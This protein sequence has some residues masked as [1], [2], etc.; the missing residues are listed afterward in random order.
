MCGGT[1]R[2]LTALL[3]T[4]AMGY[5]SRRSATDLDATPR[6]T[7]TFDELSGVRRF[8]GH[9][10]NYTTLLLEDE[11]GVLYVGARGAVFALNASNVADG[12][13]RMIHWEASPEKQLDCLQKG[14]NNKTECFNHVRFLQR[15]NTTHLYACGTYAFHPLCASIVS[16]PVPI[17]VPIQGGFGVA[18]PGHGHCHTDATGP[19]QPHGLLPVPHPS[20]SRGVCP[21]VPSCSRQVC[22]RSHGCTANL[23]CPQPLEEPPHL[24]PSLFKVL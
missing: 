23:V 4:A 24:A 7:V 18:A 22:A 12:S 3:V 5:P 9:S 11:R 6:M 14:K 17:A 20:H 13:H 15:L 10:L 2:L 16:P 19:R 1:V 8:S 21:R